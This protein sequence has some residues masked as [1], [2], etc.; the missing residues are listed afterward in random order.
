MSRRTYK[1]LVQVL[2]A[3]LLLVCAVGRSTAQKQTSPTTKATNTRG[4][5]PMQGCKA[6]QMRCMNKQHRMEAAARNA[7]RRAKTKRMAPTS[8]AGVK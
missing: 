6:G 5:K 7:D 3:V 1:V 8:P 4:L 2:L